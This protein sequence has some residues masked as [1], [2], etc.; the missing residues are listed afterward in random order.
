MNMDPMQLAQR[1]GY[2]S[3]Y[4][5]YDTQF[6]G[7]KEAIGWTWWDVNN[8]ATAATN[9]LAFFTTMKA[10]LNLSNMQN[11][12]QLASPQAF[13]LRAIRVKFYA[14]PFA[15]GAA[16]APLIQPSL[17]NDLINLTQ[18]GVLQLT[19]GQ[20][21]YGQWPLWMLP[22]GGGVLDMGMT[23]SVAALAADTVIDYADNGVQDP[24]AVYSLTKPLFIAPQINFR[25]DLLWPAGAVAL[26]TTS[27]LPIWVGLDGDL[28]RPVQ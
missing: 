26:A 15:I 6:Q 14:Q 20:K 12:G 3:E 9:A 13:F 22:A 4:N 19:V 8:Y 2:P 27:P 11:A 5:K 21:I 17:M 23:V 10:T 25:C 7:Q 1:Y 28:I 24:R 16:I 18:G